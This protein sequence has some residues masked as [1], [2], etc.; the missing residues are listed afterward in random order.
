MKSV[1]NPSSLFKRFFTDK[2]MDNIVQYT[3]KRMQPV[4]NKFSD[5]FD[6]STKY[7][8]VNVKPVDRIE[9]E[10][11]LGVLYLRAAFRLNILDREVI[12]N[13]ESVHDIVGAT[14]S[15][16]NFDV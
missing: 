2:M 8:H 15:L 11:F 12:W 1:K 3:Y 4:I 10:S 14:M 13:H 5:S 9:I 6:G 16:K 7:S